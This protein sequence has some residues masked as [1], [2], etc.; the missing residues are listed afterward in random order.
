[1]NTYGMHKLVRNSSIE[2]ISSGGAQVNWRKLETEE[3]THELARKLF[4]EAEELV[5]A[6]TPD[7]RREEMA[8]ILEILVSMCEANNLTLAEV[9][10]ARQAKL[11]KRGNFSQRFYIETITCPAGSFWDAYCAKDPAKYPRQKTNLKA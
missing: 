11:A 9:E 3:F 2:N 8:D 7:E 10:A 6:T 1:M 5:N 4:E